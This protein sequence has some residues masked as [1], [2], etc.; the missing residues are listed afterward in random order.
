MMEVAAKE[1]RR[2]FQGWEY[3]VVR[4]P[5]TLHKANYFPAS[6]TIHDRD[7]IKGISGSLRQR[8][9]ARATAA[10]TIAFP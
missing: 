7:T 6:K 4:F 9:S 3:V 1:W 10:G 8:A 2:A 5:E